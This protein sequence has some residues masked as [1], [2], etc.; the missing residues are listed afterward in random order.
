MISS[1]SSFVVSRPVASFWSFAWVTPRRVERWLLLA[2]V[3]G[4][5]FASWVLEL[6]VGLFWLLVSVGASAFVEFSFGLRDLAL[7]LFPWL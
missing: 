6:V 2:L 7:A 3:F 1:C 5:G 4:S